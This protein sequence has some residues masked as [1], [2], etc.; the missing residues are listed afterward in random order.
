M[1]SGT[2]E[3]T[4]AKIKTRH[5]VYSG[6]LTKFVTSRSYFA[7]YVAYNQFY[8]KSTER[9]SECFISRKLTTILEFCL[10]MSL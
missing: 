7:K 5:I 2:Y 1:G 9:K 4:A 6:D 10:Q 3:A 8:N